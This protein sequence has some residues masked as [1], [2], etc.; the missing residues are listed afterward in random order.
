MAIILASGET[1]EIHV[2]SDV[3][4]SGVIDMGHFDAQFRQK[5]LLKHPELKP[6][7]DALWTWRD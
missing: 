7:F 2:I 3:T 4:E 1:V 6:H 5:L